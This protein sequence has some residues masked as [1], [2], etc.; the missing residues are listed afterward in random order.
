M[1]VRIH[2]GLTINLQTLLAQKLLLLAAAA[3]HGLSRGRRGEPWPAFQSHLI[4]VSTHE[5]VGVE[6]IC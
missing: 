3:V 2:E 1:W 5:V 6:G 4:F